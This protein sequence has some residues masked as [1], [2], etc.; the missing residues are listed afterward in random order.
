MYRVTFEHICEMSICTAFK[1]IF[2][3]QTKAAEIIHMRHPLP[4]L[5][6][7]DR[8]WSQFIHTHTHTYSHS[9]TLKTEGIY[10]FIRKKFTNTHS[11]EILTESGIM[12]LKQ[13]CIFLKG[14][15]RRHVSKHMI[16]VYSNF[17]S[18]SLSTEIH[19]FFG[20]VVL[21]PMVILIS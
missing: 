6:Y 1:P 19:Y 5:A 18:F 15:K 21:V 8:S 9:L 7:V 20:I 14:G 12:S 2:L 17:S 11:S 3:F 16:S 10:S 13:P 4:H